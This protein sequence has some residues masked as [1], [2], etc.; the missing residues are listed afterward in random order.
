[1]LTLALGRLDS[2]R[3]KKY[4]RRNVVPE[5]TRERNERVKRG[6]NSCIRKFGQHRKEELQTVIGK[7]M[8]K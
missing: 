8:K 7:E 4:R 2:I 5:W 3:R 1:M 6:V